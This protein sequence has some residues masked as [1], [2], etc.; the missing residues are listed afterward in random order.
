MLHII[1]IAGVCT[2]IIGI[3]DLTT[4]YFTNILQN[5]GNLNVYN[6]ENSQELEDMI[7]QINEMLN[8]VPEK[9]SS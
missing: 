2:A 3:D 6:Q 1:V 8:L 9:F 7:F 4:K 5:A